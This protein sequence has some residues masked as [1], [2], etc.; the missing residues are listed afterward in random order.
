MLM[1]WLISDSRTSQW[2]ENKENSNNMLKVAA[3][4]LITKSLMYG[5]AVAVSTIFALLFF[6]STVAWVV[7]HTVWFICF[8]DAEDMKLSKEAC[9]LLESELVHQ[10]MKRAADVRSNWVTAEFKTSSGLKCTMRLHSI[11]CISGTEKMPSNCRD[12][13]NATQVDSVNGIHNLSTSSS[14]KKTPNTSGMLSGKRIK[15]EDKIKENLKPPKPVLFWLHGAGGTA[16]L[17]FGISGIMDRLVDDY[18]VYALDLP[19]FGRS[20]IECSGRDS[21]NNASGR[22]WMERCDVILQSS[23]FSVP[24][25]L[26]CNLIPT[27]RSYLFT[28]VLNFPFAISVTFSLFCSVLLLTLHVYAPAF[29]VILLPTTTTCLSN[30]HQILSI[31]CEYLCSSSSNNNS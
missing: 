17:S 7:L 11:I 26:H 15:L 20:T 23:I 16:I 3:H 8:I 6:C 13:T 29:I 19:G 24:F 14:K 1:S 30:M 10:D 27:T 4:T 12:D 18:D 21:M 31:R 5:S 28:T 2:G 25:F 9:D 22:R